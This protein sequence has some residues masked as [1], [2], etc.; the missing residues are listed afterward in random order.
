MSFNNV[1]FSN[2]DAACV[3]TLAQAGKFVVGID[4]CK[5]GPGSSYN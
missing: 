4:C 2:T 5:L 3:T 1:D